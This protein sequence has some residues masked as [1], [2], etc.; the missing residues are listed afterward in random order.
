[1]ISPSELHDHLKTVIVAPMTTQGFP[2]PF[3]INVRHDGKDGLIVL[4]QLRTV[5]QRRLSQ[6]LGAV[7]ANTLATAL[8]TLQAMFTP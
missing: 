6:R 7:P 4:D 5:D 1:V 3:R 8:A 2:A